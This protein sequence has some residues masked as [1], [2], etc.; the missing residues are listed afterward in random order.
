MFPFRTMHKTPSKE[1]KIPENCNEV[2]LVLK[3]NHEKPIIK[4][5]V[6]DVIKEELITKADCKEI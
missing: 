6:I 3:I 2:V 4:T 1:I 5:G